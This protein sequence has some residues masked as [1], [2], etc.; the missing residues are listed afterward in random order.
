MYCSAAVTS[1][2][3]QVHGYEGP[4]GP[5]FIPRAQQALNAAWSRDSLLVHQETFYVSQDRLL[6]TFQGLLHGC[7]CRVASLGGVAVEAMT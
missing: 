4:D 7:P 5:F 2:P 1:R 3:D 6:R